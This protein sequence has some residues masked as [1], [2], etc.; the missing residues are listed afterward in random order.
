M[1]PLARELLD[2]TRHAH[3]PSSEDRLRVRAKLAARI[4]AGALAGRGLTKKA[5]ASSGLT[6]VKLVVPVTLAGAVGWYLLRGPV[7]APEAPR[8]EERSAAV[9]AAS[10]APAVQLLPGAAP[11]EVAS[12]A[13]VSTA[14]LDSALRVAQLPATGHSTRAQPSADL[15]AEMGL[16]TSSQAAIQRGDYSAAL[17]KLDEH[18][19]AFPAG[20]LS[21]ER[22]AARI[23]ALCGA[24]RQAE[25]RS[26]AAAFLARHPSSPLA[27]RV[28]GSCAGP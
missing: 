11:E 12:T 5:L 24:G 14:P 18:Q 15:E 21:E 16:L 3:D 25:A 6:L 22:T 2:E 19:K 9:A 20:V 26:L 27:P 10:S 13:S 1:D 28:R 8:V 17:A 4:G 7:G 23:V